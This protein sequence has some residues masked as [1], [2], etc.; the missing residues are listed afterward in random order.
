MLGPEL[1]NERKAGRGTELEHWERAHARVLTDSHPVGATHGHRPPY[2]RSLGVRSR[3]VGSVI[4][5]ARERWSHYVTV[6]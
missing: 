5:E 1:S 6:S 4:V 2:P 3:D